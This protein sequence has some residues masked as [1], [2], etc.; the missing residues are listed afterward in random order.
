MK[1]LK[2][3][4]CAAF[5]ASGLAVSVFA[6]G[7]LVPPGA[8]SPTMKTLVQVEPRIDLATLGGNVQ[9]EIAITIPGSYYLSG[10]LAVG[11]ANGILVLAD[12]VTLDLNGFGI[13]RIS[14]SGG[15]GISIAGGKD[16]IT[17]RNG[18][19]RGFGYGIRCDSSPEYAKS[20]LFENVVVSDCS[21]Y[22]L[23]G[24]TA[25]RVIGCSVSD[26]QGIGI[27]VEPG[28]VISG[29]TL[30]GIQGYGIWASAGCT[31]NQCS[32]YGNRGGFAIYAD[33]G[34]VVSECAVYDHESTQSPGGGISIGN[35]GL[36]QACSVDSTTTTNA[37]SASGDAIGIYAFH[38]ATVRDCTVVGNK[39]D[40]ILIGSRCLVIGNL[41]A[42]NGHTGDGAGIH[43]T[44]TSNR[45]EANNATF[46]DRGIHV[47]GSANLIARN[48][49]GGNTTNYEIVADNKVGPVVS[50]PNSIAISG[51]SGG[52]GLGSTDPWANFTY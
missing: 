41:C 47:E 44:S 9:S 30:H 46:N 15:N 22:G 1:K 31:I 51:S 7:S 50:A 13:I 38:S 34:S 40:G 19:L 33:V 5:A 36:V 8:P 27:Q 10:N 32:A 48:T 49:A 6:Q 25:A 20:C 43:A 37:P 12:G 17:V 18:T 4:V 35:G 39:G 26:S 16:R 11:K 24:G 3:L 42:S 45:I 52:A 23:F 2:P 14:G 28:S 21:S 29:C